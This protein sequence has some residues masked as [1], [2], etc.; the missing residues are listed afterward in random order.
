MADRIYLNQLQAVVRRDA[1]E[2]LSA[3]LPEDDGDHREGEAL[4]AGVR[5]VV[6]RQDSAFQLDA[7]VG[8]LTR[9]VAAQ[10]EEIAAIKKSKAPTAALTAVKKE[11]KQ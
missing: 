1:L 5:D 6:A 2:R 4:V 10:Q 7:L 11:I 3:L 9:V 8:A